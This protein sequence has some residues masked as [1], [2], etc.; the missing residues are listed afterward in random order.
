[1]LR[2]GIATTPSA[3]DDGPPQPTVYEG[4]VTRVVGSNV[5]VEAPGYMPHREHGPAFV[6]APAGAPVAGAEVLVAFAD[7]GEALAYVPGVGSTGGGGSS[8]PTA[9]AT[10]LKFGAE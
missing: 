10:I 5:Y 8:T 1:M 2:D 3:H 7:S 4:T 6:I 9:F